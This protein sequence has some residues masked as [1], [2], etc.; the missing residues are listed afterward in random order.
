MINFFKRGKSTSG[1]QS[2]TLN[3]LVAG[4]G[5]PG[6]QYENTRHNIGFWVLDE[7]AGRAGVKIK[8]LKF[9]SAYALT[10]KTLLLK[11][12]SFMNR[13]GQA[14][15]DA[16]AFYKIPPERIIIVYDEAAL[17]PGRL[18]LRA[19]GS[20]GGHNGMKD[21]LF[22][23]QTDGFPR[24]RIGVGGPPHPEISLADWV[25]APIPA[26]GREALDQAAGRAADAVECIIKKGIIEAM[27]QFN[28]QQS[29]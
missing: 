27:N 8:K 26:A 7:L 10:G 21:I 23:L 11:P 1:G 15:R 17:A 13:S 19:S 22:H 9:H 12:Q 4:L 6:S 20:G 14:V 25:L 29:T 18:R 2:S 28:T 16:A 24:V 3:W 5:N